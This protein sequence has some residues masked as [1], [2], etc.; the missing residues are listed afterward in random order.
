MSGRCPYCNHDDDPHVLVF[1]TPGFPLAGGIRLCPSSGCDCYST[2][3]VAG[4]SPDS[5]ATLSESHVRLL[6]REIQGGR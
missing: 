4:T 1:T 2:W 6:R 3:S 5:V